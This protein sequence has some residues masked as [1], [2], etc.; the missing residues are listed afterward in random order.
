MIL[1][2]Q[3]DVS[4][5]TTK[6]L[7]HEH[8]LAMFTKWKKENMMSTQH[9]CSFVK[10]TKATNQVCARVRTMNATNP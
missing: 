3:V 10:L 6:Q 7:V 2:C 1:L 5:C 4:F 8:S 9:K